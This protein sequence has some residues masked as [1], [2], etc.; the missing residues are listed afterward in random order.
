MPTTPG[1]VLYISYTFF[2]FFDGLQLTRV[3]FCRDIF[4]PVAIGFWCRDRLIMANTDHL[5]FGA[6]HPH[7]FKT[8]SKRHTWFCAVDEAADSSQL[9]ITVI[10]I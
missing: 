7:C 3:V 5:S 10:S 9:L 1:G 2:S 6:L 4:V 8:V